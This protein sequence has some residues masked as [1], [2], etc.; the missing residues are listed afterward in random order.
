[1]AAVEDLYLLESGPVAPAR[2]RQVVEL[3][4]ASEPRQVVVLLVVVEQFSP[5][6][7]VPL[8][9]FATLAQNSAVLTG[10]G[11]AKFG[12]PTHSSK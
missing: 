5:T 9:H 11:P 1:M 4:V 2:A 8:L 10:R 7:L 12:S 3:V 6:L